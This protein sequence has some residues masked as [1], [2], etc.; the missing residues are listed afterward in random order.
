MRWK[1]G[2]ALIGAIVALW[3]SG[4]VAQQTAQTFP[5]AFRTGR[6]LP[7][8]TIWQIAN[9]QTAVNPQS[10]LECPLKI[11]VFVRIT[12]QIY[13][14]FGTDV[15]CGYTSLDSGTI[16][17]Y[18]ALRGNQATADQE[19]E[20][21]KASIV[22]RIPNAT[23]LPDADQQTFMSDLDWRHII[24]RANGASREGLW[25]T[26][27]GGWNVEFRATYPES[28]TGLAFA[29]MS[30]L[31]AN[32]QKTAGEHIAA[33]FAMMPVARNG[34]L[35]M[36]EAMAI[37]LSV[38]GMLTA[39]NSTVNAANWCV[40]GSLTIAGAPW[41]LWRNAGDQ[42]GGADRL[43]SVAFENAP[44]IYSIADNRWQQALTGTERPNEPYAIAIETQSAL[45]LI[46]LDEGRPTVQQLGH[47]VGMQHLPIYGH[48]EKNTHKVTIYR[49]PLPPVGGVPATATPPA[50]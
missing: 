4:A 15:S 2:L 8:K 34:Q 27:F 21:G 25:M 37:R 41:L 20:A 26:R 3:A 19:F 49:P 7:P 11:D 18:I 17:F 23:P 43:T 13:T 31:S 30:A 35:I 24:Y 45:E 38:T 14:P 36:N 46:G 9:D 47:F 50:P 5:Q 22:Q 32:A 6:D 33:C 28:R 48:L 29:A 39:Q 40:Q 16:T 44:V 42:N 12:L 1:S 10:R